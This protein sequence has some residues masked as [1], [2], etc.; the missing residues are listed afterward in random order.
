MPNEK[1]HWLL[2]GH[3]F[4]LLRSKKPLV[5][6][7]VP[8]F[9]SE[10]T[11]SKCLASIC[12]QEYPC[13]QTLVLDGG[14]RDHTIDVARRF[15]AEVSSGGTLASRRK[16]GITLGK[17]KYILMI[18][19]D[20]ILD[21]K[22][23]S[24]CV[25][26]C[27]KNSFDMLVLEERPIKT[28]TL[29]ERAFRLD[30]EL[31]HRSGRLDPV[32]GTLLPRFFRREFV[33]RAEWPQ[34]TTANDHAFLYYSCTKLGGE[35]GIAHKCLYHYDPASLKEVALKF[36]RWGYYYAKE[37]RLNPKVS[38]FHVMPRKEYFSRQGL[39]NP[40][41]IVLSIVYVTK[42]LSAGLGALRRLAME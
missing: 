42:I 22:A 6:V 37:V 8:T 34:E 33:A 7:I 12:E 17:G 11:L 19:S 26:A 39:G 21:P 2:P 40:L 15:G 18:D 14:S 1:P 9:N 23:V 31:V 30:R 13:I 3:G 41:M 36:Y 16:L 24:K 25:E 5:S 28:D 20:Q 10:R 32:F 29:I 4:G 35:I 27:E 38:G